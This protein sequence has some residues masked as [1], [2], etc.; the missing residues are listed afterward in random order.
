MDEVYESKA[1]SA[2]RL[3]ILREVE[4]VVL[5]LELLV[6]QL[7]HVCLVEFNRNISDH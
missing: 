6:E 4:I 1:L 7:Q 2:L 5:T 3:E